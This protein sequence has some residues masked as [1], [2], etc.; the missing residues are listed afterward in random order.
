M[1]LII[2]TQGRPVQTATTVILKAEYYKLQFFFY[3]LVAL[4]AKN[5]PVHNLIMFNRTKLYGA[6]VSVV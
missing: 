4:R 6:G 1:S 5:G 3:F 2:F